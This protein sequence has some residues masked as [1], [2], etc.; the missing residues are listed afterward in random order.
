M[1]CQFCGGTGFWRD[2]WHH[3]TLFC[4]MCSAIKAE[5]QGLAR[6]PSPTWCPA[7]WEQ[8]PAKYY[9][10]RFQVYPGPWMLVIHSGSISDNVAEYISDPGDDREVS[11][12]VCWSGGLGGYVQCVP[13]SH[14]AWHCGGSRFMDYGRLNYCSIGIELPGPWDM[15][16][17]GHKEQTIEA[18]RSLLNILPSLRTVVRHSDINSKKKDP[19][20]GFSWDWLVGLDVELPFT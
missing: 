11:A 1:I 13:L 9:G 5:H 6:A 17:S 16:R 7:I 4:P 3:Q 12:H 10:P 14:V 18:I 15:D 20:P 19:G 8:M 2:D